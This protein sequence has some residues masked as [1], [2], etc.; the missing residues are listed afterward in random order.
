LSCIA[1]SP[2]IVRQQW[3]IPINV[4]SLIRKCQPKTQSRR[5]FASLGDRPVGGGKE[6]SLLIDFS[7]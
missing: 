3:L 7:S 5:I 4:T 1:C 6:F 2:G